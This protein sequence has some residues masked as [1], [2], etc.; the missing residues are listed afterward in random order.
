MLY[1][2]Y[3]SL[4]KDYFGAALGTAPLVFFSLGALIVSHIWSPT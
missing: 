3:L 1:N 2:N 4:F